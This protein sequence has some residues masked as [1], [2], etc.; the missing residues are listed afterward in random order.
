MKLSKLIFG[1]CLIELVF[2][3]VLSKTWGSLASS[4]TPA[5]F[6]ILYFV[7]DSSEQSPKRSDGRGDEYGVLA[8]LLTPFTLADLHQ[9]PQKPL[10]QASPTNDSGLGPHTS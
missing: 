7:Q 10:R 1:Q 9:R 6:T 3:H 2:L 8:S 5:A 4:S